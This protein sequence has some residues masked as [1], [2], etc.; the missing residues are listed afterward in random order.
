MSNVVAVASSADHRFSKQT[1]PEIRLLE[2]LGVE[3]DA[4]CG[5]TV[6]HLSRVAVDPN[7]PNLRQVHLLPLELLA[8]LEAKGFGV[9]PGDLGENVT[10]EGIDLIRMPRGTRLRLGHEAEVEISGLRNPC[11]QIEAFQAGML[12]E[13][14]GKNELGEIERRAGVMA[15]VLKGGIV[16]PG[17]KIAIELPPEPHV[18]LERV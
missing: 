6:Q 13:V 17:D 4:H 8:E 7:Q 5:R 3:G 16:R 9:V 11:A 14:V 18:P 1:G 10:T 15:V 2:G 12:A